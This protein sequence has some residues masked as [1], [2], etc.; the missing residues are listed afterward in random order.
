[1]R[2]LGKKQ[3]LLERAEESNHVMKRS[4]LV[5]SF[6]I[7]L[8]MYPAAA[9][10]QLWNGVITPNRATDWSQVGIP[11]GLPDTNWTQ[12]GSTIGAYTGT[13]A[14]IVNQLATCGANQFVLLGPGTFNLSTGINFPAN[15][16]GHL[17]L[18]GSGANST[19]LVFTGSGY[20]CGG[21][22]TAYICAMSNDG[23]YAG[24]AANKVASWTGN[25]AQGSSQ[26]ILSS[27]AGITVNKTLLVLNQC[28]TGFSGATCSTGNSIDN[29]NYFVCSAKYNGTTGC[30]VN[31]PD[32]TSWRPNAWQ[33]EVV[34]ATAINQGGCGAT[35]VTI[36]RP[37]MHP[38]WASSQSP[39]AVL[40]N[41][42]PQVGIENLAIDGLAG[43]SGT[44]IFMYNAFQGWVSGVKLTNMK[45]WFINGV[46]VVNMLIK[47]NYIYHANCPTG[48]D[49]YGIRVQSGANNLIQ[50]NIVQQVRLATANGDGP[51]P[52]SVIAYNFSIQQLY[53]SD[54]MFGANWTHSAGDDFQ[55]WEG[56]IADQL[57][58][59]NLHG[60]HLNST[61]FR[62]FYTGWE[63]CATASVCGGT[64]KDS[65][66]NAIYLASNV[67]YE[68]IIGNVAGTPGYHNQYSSTGSNT[69]V[70]TLGNGNGSVTPNVPNDPLTK[71]TGLF[72]G[73]Y[74]T[75]T[76]AV[77]WCG[78]SSNTG[79]SSHCGGVSE[80]PTGIN[81]FPNAL[82]TVGDT[83]A[84]QPTLPPSFYLSSKPSW[85]GSLPW[86][87][88]GPD[89]TGGNIGICSGLLNT[90]GQFSGLPATSSLQCA[91]TTLTT[92]AWGGHVN[93]NPAMNCYL[94]V[95]GGKPDGTGAAL[96]FDPKAC[97]GGSGVAQGP[98]APTNLILVINTI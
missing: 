75:V 40:L 11:G 82:P 15:T 42:I 20:N 32:G 22:G 50:N 68:N 49:P 71:S 19:F 86:P 5:L 29:G 44:G 67:R 38:N 17:A 37:I 72:W 8:L 7:L 34:L 80:V 70:F 92:S 59:D 14:T 56:N 47:D 57:Q 65:S 9:H 94:N 46:N 18:R 66:T 23:T 39:Q 28:D 84:G 48:C 24:N 53:A 33:T 88:I 78:S 21:F 41:P 95:M 77:R 10:A 81:P 27:V 4:Q 74:D 6:F 26:I 16:T 36:S 12:C 83:G 90:L 31:G 51:D 2:G 61:V 85:F 79:W 25:Y 97:Y 76:G 69:S 54:F 93:T 64:V 98:A 62:N 73:N 1:M 63:S 30:A 35:C 60:S 43:G 96:A 45:A 55:L 89:V 91:L 13:A 58:N 52:G 3:K 87:A